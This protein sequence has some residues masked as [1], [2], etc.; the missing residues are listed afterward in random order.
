MSSEFWILKHRLCLN[1]FQCH[2]HWK[3]PT[4]WGINLT[5]FIYVENVREGKGLLLEAGVSM[6]C[7]EE[8]KVSSQ[9]GFI[10]S[11]KTRN[12]L[13]VASSTFSNPTRIVD[14]AAWTSSR[15]RWTSLNCRLRACSR[16]SSKELARFWL[17]PWAVAVVGGAKERLCNLTAE[18]HWPSLA[19]PCWLCSRLLCSPLCLPFLW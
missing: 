10:P 14:G 7:L 4:W 5:V 1:S 18:E 11:W 19:C 13:S 16:F 2:S 6:E 3:H 15:H 9:L 12:I 8:K 17:C